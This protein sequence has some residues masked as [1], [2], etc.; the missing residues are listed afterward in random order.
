[1]TGRNRLVAVSLL[2]TGPAVANAQEDPAIAELNRFLARWSSG[3]SI[4]AADVNEL[5]APSVAYYGRRLSRLQITREKQAI[6]N[7]WPRRRY[8]IE[9]SSVETGCTPERIRCTV[10]GVLRW[11]VANSFG[12]GSSGVSNLTL[13]LSRVGPGYQIV[14]E[15]GAVAKRR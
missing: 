5:Y 10:R 7:K 13:A 9:P 15:S 8:T 2:L 3:P 4:N 14:S 12:K 11:S 6:A 1:M